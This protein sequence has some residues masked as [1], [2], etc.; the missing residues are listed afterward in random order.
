MF[1]SVFAWMHTFQDVNNI[2]RFD[3]ISEVLMCSG[4]GTAAIIKR[5]LVYSSSGFPMSHLWCPNEVLTPPADLDNSDRCPLGPLPPA[6]IPDGYKG[7]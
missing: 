5:R 7:L 6:N 1:S 4:M 2:S 3:L